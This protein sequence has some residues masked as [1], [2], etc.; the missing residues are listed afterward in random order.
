MIHTCR[1]IAAAEAAGAEP[2][3][4]RRAFATLSR[5]ERTILALVYF[6]ELSV[7]DASIALGVTQANAETA[8]HAAL[9]AL[10]DALALDTRAETRVDLEWRLRSWL[11]REA[12][13]P[14]L[15]DVAEAVAAAARDHTAA[16]TTAR[17]RG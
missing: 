10:R 17:R 13:P 8:L 6:A 7:P 2:D 15:T 1:R 14:D 3:D 9:D 11:A 4:S 12:A 16:P 5:D